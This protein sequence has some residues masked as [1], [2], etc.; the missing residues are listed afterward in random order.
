MCIRDSFIT[1]F[2]VL[3]INVNKLEE[4]QEDRFPIYVTM[5]VGSTLNAT[6]LV[7]AEIESRLEEVEERQDIISNIQEEDAIITVIMQEDY[8]KIKDRT[9]A[10]IKSQVEGLVKNIAQAE[11]SLTAPVSGSRFG[12]GGRGGGMENFSRFLGI[13]T[14][15]ERIEMCIRDRNL[16]T[17]TELLQFLF[18]ADRNAPLRLLTVSYTHLDVYKRQ[19]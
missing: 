15:R 19:C 14:N 3:A 6:D 5:P 4:V 9:I 17:S 7:V 18:L 1:I 12:S 8:K 16:K 10:E 11:I 2:S 13:G